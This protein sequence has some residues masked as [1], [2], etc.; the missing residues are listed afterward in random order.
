MD[1]YDLKK[2]LA[3]LHLTEDQMKFAEAYAVDG[4]GPRAYALTGYK[5]KGKFSKANIDALLKN[6]RVLKYIKALR[7]NAFLRANLCLDDVIAEYKKMAFTNMA[8]Y[9]EWSAEGIFI[10]DK[11]DLTKDQQAGILEISETE[12]KLGKTVTIKLHPKQ[13]ALDKLYKMMTEMDDRLAAKKPKSDG[14]L[15]ISMEN[16]M[17]VLGDPKQRKAVELLAGGFLKHDLKITGNMQKAIENLTTNIEK[18]PG[19]IDDAMAAQ[20]EAEKYAE[21]DETRGLLDEHGGES[22]GR[23]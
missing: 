17:V 10:K 13:A 1:M 16:V 21:C 6:E 14:K 5:S 23:S 4:N 12:T 8:D 9:M 3:E 18:E 22:A 2:L 15:Q 7:D 19:D 20:I 11:S